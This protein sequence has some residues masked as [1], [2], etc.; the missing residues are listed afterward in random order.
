VPRLELRTRVVLLVHQLELRKP[1]NTGRL[2]ARCLP[3]STMVVR[4]GPAL[5]SDAAWV[6]AA[7]PVLLF[8]DGDAQPLERWRDS[9]DPVTLL[10]PDGTWRQA[11]RTRRRLPGLLALP[12]AALPAPAPS[13][14]RLRSARP[15]RLSTMEAITRALGILEG[16]DVEAALLHILQVMI[17]R[18]LWSNGRLPGDSVTGGVPVGA[19]SHDPLSGAA[20]G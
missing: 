3:G 6:E 15:G 13:V 14:Y 4:G 8:P 9:P 11:A 20:R 5:P 1:T 10:V 2:A 18:M 17:D 7:A 19:V 16:P 12:C